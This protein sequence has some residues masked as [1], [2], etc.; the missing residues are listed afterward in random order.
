MLIVFAFP[1]V[2]YRGKKR[3]QM[4]DNCC[5]QADKKKRGND[6]VQKGGKPVTVSRAS[7]QPFDKHETHNNKLNLQR[8]SPHPEG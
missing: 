6:Y 8:G 3:W 7:K 5:Y 1:G 2:A 4:D